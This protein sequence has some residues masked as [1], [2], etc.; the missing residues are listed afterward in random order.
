MY[1]SEGKAFYAATYE[2]HLRYFNEGF[3]HYLPLNNDN[4]LGVTS[5]T[6][7]NENNQGS[8]SSGSSDSGGSVS[9][10][11]GDSGGSYGY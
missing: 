3:T 5:S 2:E 1:N 4:N 8:S 7:N 10:D 11:S 6:N 9:T